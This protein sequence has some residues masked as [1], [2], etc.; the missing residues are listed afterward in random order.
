MMASS[1]ELRTIYAHIVSDL[2]DFAYVLRY[3]EVEFRLICK[4]KVDCVLVR[5]KLRSTYTD[6]NV[7]SV[8]IKIRRQIE[9]FEFEEFLNACRLF[10]SRIRRSASP[11]Y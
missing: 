5:V 10:V 8:K 6:N 1:E 9:L 2:E 11:E 4:R 3:K 7:L